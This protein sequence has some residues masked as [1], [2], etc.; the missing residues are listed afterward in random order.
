MITQHIKELAGRKFGG[1]L[2]IIWKC[3]GKDKICKSFSRQGGTE[4][5]RKVSLWNLRKNDFKST[6]SFKAPYQ[7]SL[8]QLV[9]FNVQDITAMKCIT[10]HKKIKE[11][12]G[13]LGKN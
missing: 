8:K 6:I 12:L 1:L 13:A 9:E 3:G 7:S 5:I 2:T 4:Q 10:T 11:I